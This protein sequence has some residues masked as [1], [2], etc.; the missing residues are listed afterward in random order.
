MYHVNGGF[1]TAVVSGERTDLLIAK[2]A[3]EC[4][5]SSIGGSHFQIDGEDPADPGGFFEPHQ[6]FSSDPKPSILGIDGEQVQMRVFRIE[7]HDRKPSKVVTNPRSQ[8]VTVLAT[9]VSRNSWRGPR[10][11][12]SLFHEVARHLRNPLRIAQTRQLELNRLILPHRGA[13]L[14]SKL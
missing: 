4:S 3:V 10:P 13:D 7:L 6:K 14:E 9:D 1:S 2:G 5:C 8:H 12:Q 11:G